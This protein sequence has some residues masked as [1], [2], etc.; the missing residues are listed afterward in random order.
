[1]LY[2]SSTRSATDGTAVDPAS[3]MA[4]SSRID[5]WVWWCVTLPYCACLIAFVMVQCGNHASELWHRWKVG[6]R[7]KGVGTDDDIY[8]RFPTSKVTTRPM[9][10]I[11][12]SEVEEE[13]T[14]MALPCKHPFHAECL[15]KWW[16]HCPP[17]RC[18]CPVCRK[19]HE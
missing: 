3:G 18:R 4:R 14:C 11:C 2:T 16:T 1:M 10:A 7:D 17:A 9:C 12:L 15:T 5:R 6:M 19:W 8:A 13:E